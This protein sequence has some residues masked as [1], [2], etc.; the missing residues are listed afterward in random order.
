[1]TSRPSSRRS[2]CVSQVWRTPLSADKSL[3]YLSKVGQL[4]TSYGMFS[5][6]L[7]EALGM[8][9][10]GRLCLAYQLLCVAPALCQNL[11]S[12]LLGLLN[13]MRVH[14]RRFG[15]TPSLAPL[16]PGHF[17]DS[18]N[19]RVARFNSLFAFI[20]LT[21]RSQF[22]YK[23]S[24]LTEMVEH[25]RRS[26]EAAVETLEAGLT[27]RPER[28]WDILRASHYDLNTCLRESIVI[29]KCFL[30]AVP[31]EQL[32]DFQGSLKE[33]VLVSPARVTGS[34]RHLA[35]R[36]LAPIKGQ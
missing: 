26:F 14:T 31:E 10:G 27:P 22:L 16:D 25:L 6:N 34:V 4:E 32:A 30:H 3:V 17:L 28:Y 7:D 12:P 13:A 33:N 18:R 29:L 11:A 5:V 9:Q 24:A 35:H 23:V 1:L 8:R 20:P 2:D 19:Q 15:T 21:S 36:R